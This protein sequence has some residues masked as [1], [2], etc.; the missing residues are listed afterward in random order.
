MMIQCRGVIICKAFF[1]FFILNFFVGK[2]GTGKKN[3]ECVK[4]DMKD[5]GLCVKDTKDCELRRGKCFDKTSKPRKH[6]K[7][8]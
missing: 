8:T 1:T 6:V 4:L 7:K 5:L 3:G 2:T